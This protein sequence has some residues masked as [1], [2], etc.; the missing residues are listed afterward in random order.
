MTATELRALAATAAV[1]LAGAAL[2]WALGVPAAPLTG[3]A[4]AVTA[5]A[6]AGLRVAVPVWLRV[7]AFALLGIN[8]GAGITPDTLGQALTWPV[9][10]AI[11]A[12]SL[13]AGMV[14]ARAGLERW[15]G[16]DRRSATLAAAPGHLSFAIGLA[17]DVG[18]DTTRV[19]MVQSIRV[20]F[21]TLCVP[22][23]V[24]GIFGTTG[25]AVLPDAAM[26]P[27]HLALTLA[28]SLA[29][30]AGLARLSVPAAYLLAGM[31]VSALGHGTGLTPGRMPE[32]VT[33]AAFLV[34][35]TMIGSRFAGLGP[36]DV[37]HGLAAG[38][39]VTA[40]TMVFAILAVI[41]ALAALGM[42][43]ALLIVA[44]APGGV[45]AMAA[46]AVTLGL[47]PAFVATHHVIRLLLLTAII[48]ALLP[49]GR[50]A[51]TQR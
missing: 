45:E 8:I 37:A 6:L 4:A 50:P 34:M 25:L 20:L 13:V 32:G 3:P 12:A 28:A 14:V 22:V 42:S 24:A 5:A 35:G 18:A 43:P 15:L 40:V 36:R 9:S 38:A 39:W 17:M 2:F 33:V 44:Y 27:L 19:A 16:Y 1:A 49:A 47:D 23:L 46:I 30:G 48:P 7:P 21:L 11:L 31:A 26:R 10:I 29:L 41:A 51:D